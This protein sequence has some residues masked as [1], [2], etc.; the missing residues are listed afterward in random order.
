M[1]ATCRNV[2][3][4]SSHTELD[5]ELRK[6]NYPIQGESFIWLFCHWGWELNYPQDFRSLTFVWDLF[7]AHSSSEVFT[8]F[9]FPA[10]SSSEVCTHFLF[11]AHSSSEVCTHF[12]FPAQNSSEV[13]T[14]WRGHSDWFCPLSTTLKLPGHWGRD[15]LTRRLSLLTYLHM[16]CIIQKCNWNLSL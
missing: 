9:L 14:H 15:H 16:F 12:L 7:P 10:H 8:P 6:E 2:C 11:L 3:D 4:I 13:C 1:E 5:I